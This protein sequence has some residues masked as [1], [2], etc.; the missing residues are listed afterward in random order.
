[1]QLTCILGPS[2]F[3]LC[4]CV[5]ATQEALER[6][7]LA[8]CREAESEEEEEGTQ[9]IVRQPFRYGCV[10]KT[11]SSLLPPSLPPPL[12][13]LP[14]RPVTP[15]P[16]GKLLE[17]IASLKR[18][19]EQRTSGK[20]GERVTLTRDQ[21]LCTPGI[22]ATGNSNNNNK[23]RKVGATVTLVYILKL[24]YTPPHYTHTLHTHYTYR[25]PC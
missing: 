1:M 23:K 15:T 7:V 20:K 14:H 2:I 8:Y 19:S 25:T 18:A 6:A 21:S 11:L 17:I 9:N 13:S 12:L 24:I 4:V 16:K 22:D 10:F 5:F 3:F